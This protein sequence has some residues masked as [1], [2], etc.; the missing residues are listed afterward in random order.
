MCYPSRE[1]D[2]LLLEA[3]LIRHYDP[4]FNVRLRHDKHFPF[5]AV[6]PGS[7][8]EP[9]VV[10]VVS[11]ARA[12]LRRSGAGAAASRAFGPFP[13]GREATRVLSALDR[14]LSLKELRVQALYGNDPA[15]YLE[16]VEARSRRRQSHWSFLL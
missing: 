5:I 6:L 1:R 9:P 14:A 8:G 4:P 12:E 11:G 10:A 15:P 16:A 2:A 7:R 13:Q 3:R